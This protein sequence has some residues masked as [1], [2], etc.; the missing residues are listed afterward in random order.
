MQPFEVVIIGYGPVGTA[1]ADLL[2]LYGCCHPEMN[3]EPSAR[4]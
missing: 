1:L 2:G 4:S 3:L